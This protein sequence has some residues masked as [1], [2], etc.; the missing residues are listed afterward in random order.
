MPSTASRNAVPRNSGARK[1]RIFADSVSI[2][3][4]SDAADRELGDEHR[5][6]AEHREPVGA[7]SAMPN[8]KNS[9]RPMHE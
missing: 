8:G 1:M 6:R 7:A 3:A 5:R 2:S 4:S 9:A